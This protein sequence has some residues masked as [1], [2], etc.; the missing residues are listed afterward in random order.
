MDAQN[1]IDGR[2]DPAV[3]ICIPA[4]RRPRELRRAVASVLAQTASD[5]EVIVTD[6]SGVRQELELEFGDSR[7]RYVL[8]PRPLGMAANW[9]RGLSLARGRFIGLLMDDDRLLPSFVERCLAAFA[10]DPTVGAVFTNHFF[11]D[12][13]SLVARRSLLPDG[14]YD[15]FLP[16]LIRHKPVAICATL[17]RRDVWMGVLPVPDMHTADLAMHMR[18]AE[19]G[20]IFRYVDEPLMIYSVHGGQ[21]S[22]EPRFRHHNIALWRAFRFEYGSEEEALRRQRLA[23][24]LLSSAASRMQSGEVSLAADLAR[25]ATALGVPVGQ[26]TVRAR[27]IALL[28]RSRAAAFVAGRAFRVAKGARLPR[29]R[30]G[31]ERQ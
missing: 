22:G 13:R 21:L 1:T 27:L 5:L 4:H 17:M 26:L 23:E 16:L 10:D 12:G 20:C 15:H 31:Q 6:D 30:R 11:D 18:A 19:S 14:T 29:V 8:N 3:S 2:P 7:L 24:A 9:Q 25:E 28:A